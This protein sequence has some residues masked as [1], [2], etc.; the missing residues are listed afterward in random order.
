MPCDGVYPTTQSVA[1]DATGDGTR[2]FQCNE[3]GSDLWVEE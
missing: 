3:P 1:R 2:C